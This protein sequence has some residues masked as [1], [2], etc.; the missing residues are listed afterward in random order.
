MGREKDIEKKFAE[1]L[2]RILAGEEVKAD[3]SMDD[4]MRAALDFA[5]KISTLGAVPTA[6]YQARL[7]A[8]LLQKLAEQ[9]ARKKASR[10]SGW[11]IFRQPVWQG[12]IAAILVIMAITIV[13]R[14]GFFQ[15]SI[16]APAKTPATTATTAVPTTTAAPT[17]TAAPATTTAP[18]AAT[19]VSVDAKTDKLT[20]QAG[21]TVKIDI[22]MKNVSG[23]Q[24][25]VTDFPPI[26][27]LMQSDTKQPV[28]T[29]AAGKETRVL[30]SN[31]VATF[32]YTWNETDFNGRLVTGSYYVE[33]EDLEYQGHPYQ[34]NLN[35]PVHFEILR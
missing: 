16:S 30:A 14:A 12:A 28:Y 17:K 25:T 11:G 34:L 22:S 5:R 24:L 3:P 15:P 31:A 20:Y 32:T 1:Y 6:Q 10:S 23:Q 26:L 13:W 7:K 35:N 27:S 18:Y 9:E 29:F 33:L 21:E 8:S 4:E 2:D 19:L